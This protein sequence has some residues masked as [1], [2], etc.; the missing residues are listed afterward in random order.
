MNFA[1]EYRDLMI[2]ELERRSNKNPQYSMRSY[3]RDLGL[4]PS[5]LSLILNGKQGLSLSKARDIANKIFTT[6]LER[7]YFSDL[8][9]CSHARSHKK[10]ELA[11]IRLTRFHSEKAIL[12]LEAFRIISDWYHFAICE[13]TEVE[14]FQSSPLWISKSLDVPVDKVEKAISRLLKIGLLKYSNGILSQTHSFLSTTTDIPSQA[15]KE[16]H[17]QVLQK[18]QL[19]INNQSVQERDIGSIIFPM[20]KSELD[21][22]KQETRSFRRKLVDRAEQS[23]KK[24]SVYCISTQIFRMS[25]FYE[26]G[27]INV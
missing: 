10:R 8:V 21:W 25:N 24:D 20:K 9:E 27:I 16:F 1:R 12:D 2:G 11:R 5:S 19:A 17:T 14:G 18:A 3:A 4:S 7:R 6:E 26:E 13:L 15:L 23:K 22:L